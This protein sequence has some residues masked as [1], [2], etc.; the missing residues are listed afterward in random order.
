MVFCSC[1]TS[2][3][4]SGPI[5]KGKLRDNYRY[6]DKESIAIRSGCFVDC[7]KLVGRAKCVTNQRLVRVRVTQIA[8]KKCGRVSDY[9][10]RRVISALAAVA[11]IRLDAGS[12]PAPLSGLQPHSQPAASEKRRLT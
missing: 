8:G 5:V 10:K 4:A 2:G 12:F 6:C 11:S 9:P 7:D 3:G 1:M